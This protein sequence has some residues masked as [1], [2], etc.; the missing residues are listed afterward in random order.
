MSDDEKVEIPRMK[1][2]EEESLARWRRDKRGGPYGN[3]KTTRHGIFADRFL[4]KKERTMFRAVIAKLHEDFVF[5]KSS[6]YAEVELVAVYFIK[7]GRA[8]EAENWEAADKLDR[9]FCS[10]LKNLKAT[11]LA[12][13]G[14]AP[15]K[16][17]T[18]PADW[19][20]A[21]LEK[22]SAAAATAAEG[23]GSDEETAEGEPVV[24]AAI[25]GGG[26]E[27]GPE[28]SAC[29]EKTAE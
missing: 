26:G 18:S 16:S 21:I 25:E 24:A 14:E 27:S 23:G 10:H 5:N 17:E 8:I 20:T 2:H 15:Q 1:E 29:E 11:K 28:V 7:L 4:S 12:R 6:D 9:M 3:T 13:E 19:A 22:M